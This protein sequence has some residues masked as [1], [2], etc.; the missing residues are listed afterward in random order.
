M[1]DRQRRE[2]AIV[3]GIKMIFGLGIM[4]YIMVTVAAVI[5]HGWVKGLGISAILGGTGLAVAASVFYEPKK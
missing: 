1:T 3:E 4:L 5:D 2:Q